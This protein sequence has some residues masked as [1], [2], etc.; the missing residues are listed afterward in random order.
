MK[1]FIKINIILV[2]NN[3]YMKDRHEHLTTFLTY[4]SL[5]ELLVMLFGLTST[6]ATFQRFIN[7]SLYEYLD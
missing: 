1:Y 7:N 4:F 5:F 6:L 2:F 3:V